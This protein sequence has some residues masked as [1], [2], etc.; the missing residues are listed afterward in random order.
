MSESEKIEPEVVSDIS[1]IQEWMKAYP[2]SEMLSSRGYTGSEYVQSCESYMKAVGNL[3]TEENLG[4]S[5]P[6]QNECPLALQDVL[7]I[8][9][10]I[11][12]FP[13]LLLHP[14]EY[15]SPFCMD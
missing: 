5:S 15:I 2:I 6:F 14:K 11:E 10:E 7:K 1:K 9:A 13:A 12:L 8:F 4:N 3:Y